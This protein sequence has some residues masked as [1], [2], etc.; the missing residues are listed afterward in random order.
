MEDGVRWASLE[1]RNRISINSARILKLP[2]TI[3]EDMAKAEK[4][5]GHLF[6][7]YQALYKAAQAPDPAPGGYCLLFKFKDE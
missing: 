5:R 1:K 7:V 6:P 3:F 4:N 2:L